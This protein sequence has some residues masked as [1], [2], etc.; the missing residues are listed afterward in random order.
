MTAPRPTRVLLIDDRE[1]VRVTLRNILLGF[2]CVFTEAENGWRALELIPVNAFDVIILDIRLPGFSGIEIL[3]EARRLGIPLGKVIVL[4]GFPDAATRAEATELGVFRFL[5]KDPI[6]RIEVRVAF[7]DAIA[8]A[9]PNQ[10]VLSSR[11]AKDAPEASPRRTRKR[12]AAERRLLIVDSDELSLATMS[13]VLGGE[14]DVDATSSPTVAIKKVK[15]QHYKL[16]VLDM[17]MVDGSSGL[18]VLTTMRRA[19][20]DLR[21]MIIT[22]QP[23]HETAFESG[24]RGALDYVTK[25]EWATLPAVIHKAL[26]DRGRPIRVFLCYTRDD[27]STVG[28]LYERLM[29]RGFLPWM[30]RKSIGGGQDWDLEIRKAINDTDYFVCCLSER[31]VNREGPLRRE[32]NLAL[33]KQEEKKRGAPFIIPLRLEICPID[34]SLRRFEYVDYFEKDGFAKLVRTLSS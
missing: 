22:E 2:E 12:G 14:F 27:R 6:N 10:P 3:R 5:T 31:S 25:G 4:T 18:D 11:P 16:V 21:A 19:V 24:R 15:K 32:I 28:R 30:D 8:V 23:D 29:S 26:I 13:E 7:A 33:Q 20:P 9:S 17:K 34:E 1:N